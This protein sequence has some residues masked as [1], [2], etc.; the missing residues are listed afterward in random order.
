MHPWVVRIGS[1]TSQRSQAVSRYEFLLH[2]AVKKL[3]ICNGCTD[4]LCSCLI[5]LQPVKRVSF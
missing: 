1:D 2:T 5:S 4:R 3:D